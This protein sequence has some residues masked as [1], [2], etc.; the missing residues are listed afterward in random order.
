MSDS[1]RNREIGRRRVL[2]LAGS[3]IVA[4][5]VAGCAESGGDGTD[6]GDGGGDGGNGDGGTDTEGDGGGNGGPNPDYEVIN[7][8]NQ[9]VNTIDPH[10]ATDYV[11]V[12]SAL[13][14]YD[15][16]IYVSEET[17]PV[18]NIG[19]EWNVTDQGQTWEFTLRDDVTFHSGNDLTAEDVVYSMDRARSLQRGFSSLWEGFVTPGD[20]EVVDEQTVRF[21]LSKPY[22]PFLATLVMFFVV[23]S[24]V[25][26]NNEES[27]DHGDRGDFGEAYLGDNIA[28]SGP[29]QV[30]QWDTGNE[31]QY[32]AYKDYW[33]GWEENQF[34]QAR[35]T[36]ITEESTQKQMM[37]AGEADMSTQF[38]SPEA[39]EEM[40]GYGNVKVPEGVINLQI[41]HLP[42]NTRQEPFDDINV[43]KAIA[44]AFDYQ[45]AME[46]IMPGSVPCQG[47]VPVNMPGH[48]ENIEPYQQDLDAAQSFLEDAE[49]SVDEINQMG[50]EISYVTDFQAERRI[51]L[52]LQNNLKEIGITNAEINPIQWSKFTERASSA[53]TAPDMMNVFHMAKFPSPDSHTYLMHH[54]SAMGSWISAAWYTEEELTQTLEDARAATNQEE[55]YSLYQEAQKMIADAYPSVFILNPPYRIALNKNLGGWTYRGVM[56]F[57]LRFYDMYRDGDGRAK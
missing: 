18:A 51:S 12:A 25:V 11:A 24:Q 27:G 43:R 50:I 3:G 42:M 37:K 48:N 32:E 53:D 39:Y 20:T 15:P 45:T 19:T 46:K 29:Y 23:D 13:N 41:F 16:L 35:F 2:K 5:S 54:P 56:S 26:K 33:G 52:L 7:L 28:G 36:I 30:S 40:S 57:Q 6:G 14:T 38:L 10:K 4:G 34:G 49:Y 9:V 22:G 44:H 21:N 1:A 31:I 55:R 8:A 47:P 17:V